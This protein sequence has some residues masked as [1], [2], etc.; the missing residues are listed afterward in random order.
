MDFIQDIKA[1]EEIY[2]RRPSDAALRKV[3]RRL[4]PQY[5][6]WI[7]AS[8]F[9]VVSTVGPEG[10]DGSPRG[11][12]G[13][14]V[15][16]LDPGTL[17]LPDWNGNNRVDTL[18]NIVR[19]G[20]IAL[21]FL[22]SGSRSAVRVNG[23]AKL[24]ADKALCESFA[25]GDKLPRTVILVEIEEIYIQCAR[26]IMRSELWESTLPEG[27]PSF[28][29][30]IDEITQGEISGAAFDQAWPARAKESMW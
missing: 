20:R 5:A 16:A 2:S 24:T 17:A 26:A 12:E 9:C 10:A 3:T 19:D 6:K 14:V 29:D 25:R 7:E 21:M 13:P 27:L 4:T 8:R 15:R 28:G 22:V 11:D 30:I 18:R 23:R 1:L